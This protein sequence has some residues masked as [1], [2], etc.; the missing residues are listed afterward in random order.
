MLKNIFLGIIT[1]KGNLHKHTALLHYYKTSSYDYNFFIGG[2]VSVLSPYINTGTLDD[3]I[4]IKY[5][6]IKMLEYALGLPEKYDYIAKVDDDTYLDLDLLSLLDFKNA[7]YIGILSSFNKH[8]IQI[9]SSEMYYKLKTKNPKIT[10]K[11]YDGYNEDFKYAMGGCYFLSRSIA[12]K[13]VKNFYNKQCPFY[14]EDIT[15][16]YHCHIN[17]AKLLDLGKLNEHY[18]FDIAAEGLIMHPISYLLMKKLFKIKDNFK[19]IKLLEDYISLNPY[20]NKNII[21]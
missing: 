9:N 15:I 16:G 13:I 14:Q 3:Y 4:N 6:V 11:S 8:K 17:N 10:F 19:K 1:H 20:Y 2:D 21:K 7:D 12:E 18:F 5:K